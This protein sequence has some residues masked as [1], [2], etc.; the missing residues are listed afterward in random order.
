MVIIENK[1]IPPAATACARKLKKDVQSAVP[2][3]IWAFALFNPI[4][5]T[6]SGF[7]RM[8][9][10]SPPANGAMQKPMAVKIGTF[11]R[12]IL[13]VSAQR[14]EEKLFISYS[15]NC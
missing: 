1:I 11:E 13:S 15:K 10:K 14:A 8:I 12:I 2:V 7:F 9:M 6:A 3:S 5:F 4:D